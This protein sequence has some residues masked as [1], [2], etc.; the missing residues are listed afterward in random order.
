MSEL[1]IPPAP[2]QSRALSRGYRFSCFTYDK[3]KQEVPGFNRCPQ[4]C[5]GENTL[6]NSHTAMKRRGFYIILN[7][8]YAMKR[9][10]LQVKQWGPQG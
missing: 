6:R 9:K 8:L 10:Y 3:R 4:N 7:V 5:G 1:P 2:R